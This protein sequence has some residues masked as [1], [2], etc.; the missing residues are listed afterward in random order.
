[1]VKLTKKEYLGEGHVHFFR[2][3][4]T[5]ELVIRPCSKKQYAA[6]GGEGGSKFNPVPEEGFEWLGSAGGTI[7]VDTASSMLEENQYCEV[8]DKVHV[9]VLGKGEKFDTFSLP[10]GKVDKSGN[11]DEKKLDPIIE[12][13][14]NRT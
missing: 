11:F 9:N 2:N 12:K 6:M 8:E 7:K 14:G 3:I 10:I 13:Y 5:G 1:M 4:A